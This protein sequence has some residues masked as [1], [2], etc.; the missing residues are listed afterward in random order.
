MIEF[1]ESL[2]LYLFT[3]SSAPEN[4]IWLI[5]FSTS[6][7][8]IPIPLSLMVI[9]FLSLSSITSTLSFDKSV[10][11]SPTDLSVF[12]FCV[13]STALETS[14]LKN[15]SLSEYKN[16]FIIGKIFSVCTL[17]LPFFFIVCFNRIAKIKN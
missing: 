3:N 15:I 13:A 7:P 9:V 2:S 10:L 12:N 11:N 8:V 6:S 4:A 1:F 17:I 16:C 5:Y 14:S